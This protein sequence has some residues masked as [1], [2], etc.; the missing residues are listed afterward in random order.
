VFAQIGAWLSR[1]STHVQAL[2]GVDPRIY[3][4]LMFACTPPFYAVLFLALKAVR[5]R[6]RGRAA[7]F[8][9]LAAFIYFVP[10]FYLLA[11][12]H[13]LP[14]WMWSVLGALVAWGIASLVSR[15][16]RAHKKQRVPQ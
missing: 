15:I 6:A 12:G 8:T 10:T 5:K 7:S 14:W 16:V 13:D 4:G 2:Y 1:L 11:F 3:V 9:G